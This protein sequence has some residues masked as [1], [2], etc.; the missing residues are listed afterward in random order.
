MT[1]RA[2][3]SPAMSYPQR[4][5]NHEAIKGGVHSPRLYLESVLSTLSLCCPALLVFLHYS[6]L[7]ISLK[8][9]LAV[10]PF[11]QHIEVS[12]LPGEVDHKENTEHPCPGLVATLKQLIVLGLVLSQAKHLLVAWG[13][14]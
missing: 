6:P 9:I 2:L 10:R 7:G 13:W 5:C 3:V 12:N 14:A 1:V 11:A 8:H 4:Q